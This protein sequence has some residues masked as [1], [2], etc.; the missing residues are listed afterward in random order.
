VNALFA[1]APGV[2][3]QFGHSSKRYHEFLRAPA[4]SAGLYLL[5][6]GATDTQTP[7]NED[8]IYYV[9]RG[10]ARMKVGE[11]DQEVSTGSVIFVAAKAEHR[12][13]DIR[14]ELALLVVFAPAET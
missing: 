9:I 8:E 4:M 6:A 7:H 3:Q 1:S 11:Q 5:P 2:E 12:F 14:E 13:Y 10:Q